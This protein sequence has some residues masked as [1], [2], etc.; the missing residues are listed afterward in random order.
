MEKTTKDIIYQSI[1]EQTGVEPEDIK[2][3]DSFSE[4]LH[5]QASDIADFL[6][7]LEE[8]GI[9]ISK[10]DMTKVETVQEFIEELNI[11]L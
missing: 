8:K 9:D 4:D 5:M 11:D 1:S 7:S 10:V 3:E 2:T 6:Q